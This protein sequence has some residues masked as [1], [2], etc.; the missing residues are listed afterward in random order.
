[1]KI[2]LVEDDQAT[3][4]ALSETL[5]LN[6]YSV[7]VVGDGEMALDLAGA[8][9]YD[10]ILLDIII[11]KIDGLHVCQ[12]LRSQNCRVPIL[13]LTA[14]DSS[15]DRVMGLDAGADDYLVKPFDLAELL[16]RMRALLR[17]GG[18]MVSPTMTWEKLHFNPSTCEFTYAGQALHLTPKEYGLLELLILNPCR[19]FSRS[20]IIDH[21]W[22]SD[23]FPG[24]E[25]VNTHMKTLRQK[26]KAAGASADF[27]E[28]VYG[29][30]YRLKPRPEADPASSSC[31]PPPP[32]AASNGGSSKPQPP[33]AGSTA[34]MEQKLAIAMVELK[35]KFA[36]HFW[37]QLAVLEQAAIAF[38][39]HTM[40]PDLQQRS[41]QEAHKLAGS[42]GIFG[43]HEGSQLARQ[44]ETLLQSE[45]SLT[46]AEMVQFSD[47]FAQLQRELRPS[48][49]PDSTTSTAPPPRSAAPPAAEPRSAEPPL[50]LV[51]DDDCTLTELLTL[52]GQARGFQVQVAA[53]LSTGRA[54]LLD[55]PPAPEQNGSQAPAHC[56][57]HRLPDVVL[58]DLHFPDAQEDGLQ[59]LQELSW[60]SPPLPVAV[61]TRQG[62][63]STRITA[64]RWGASA[65]L[66]KPMRPE[67]IFTV[68]Q[69]LQRRA[70]P[71]PA[72]VLVV[73]DDRA[74]LGAIATLLEAHFLQVVTLDNPQQ[75]W[76]VLTHFAPDLL[77]LDIEMPAFDGI[78]LCRAV[79]TDPHWA[80]LPILVL[81]AH[82]EPDIRRRIFAAGAD[83]YI[84]KPFDDSDLITRI[85]SRL[86]RLRLISLC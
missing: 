5:T 7:D 64:A 59:L 32:T 19:I 38:S 56:P 31:P 73:D 77:L 16:A 22:T 29:L 61:F 78:E 79:R 69:Q 49:A 24:E 74:I 75:F 46:A 41:R 81:S 70:D 12:H 66:Q 39:N 6:H 30:G 83:E 65:F 20:A 34:E 55:P 8:F 71:H 68:V 3:A 82:Q 76:Q 17:R 28:T 2:L 44:L 33:V 54:V 57:A 10:L 1:M 21:L 37:G 52:E 84:R 47:C 51:I 40:N 25:A 23:T 18:G 58:L 53:T 43:L 72:R 80:S 50:L 9:D 62:D 4:T 42:L 13:L 67:Q 60:H 27:I 63:V 15:G 85:N 11:P 48:P 86:A 35:K 36:P 45:R 14:K 26:L